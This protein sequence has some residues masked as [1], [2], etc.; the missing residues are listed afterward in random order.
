MH[1]RAIKLRGSKAFPESVILGDLL[2]QL[3]E[4]AGARAEH[5]T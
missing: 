4:N 3:A 1:L 5:V 2:A